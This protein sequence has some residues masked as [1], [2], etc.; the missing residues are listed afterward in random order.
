MYH[1][2]PLAQ[3]KRRTRVYNTTA[4]GF[5]HRDAHATTTPGV[6]AGLGRC[7]CIAAAAAAARYQSLRAKVIIPA[8]RRRCGKGGGVRGGRL[9]CSLEMNGSF[10][11]AWVIVATTLACWPRAR[12]GLNDWSKAWAGVY[13]NTLINFFQ[14]YKYCGRYIDS[15]YLKY[16]NS[17]YLFPEFIYVRFIDIKQ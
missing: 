13:G 7:R 12:A 17:R 9:V 3:H 8:R 1:T 16:E 5:L 2:I 4:S 6:T 10:Y 11:C 15:R 14:V